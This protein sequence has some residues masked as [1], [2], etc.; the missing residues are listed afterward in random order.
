MASAFK[1]DK[2]VNDPAAPSSLP[3]PPLLSSHP[4]SSPP[5]SLTFFGGAG[6]IGGNKILL[7]TPRSKIYLDFGQSFDFGEDYFYEWLEPRAANGLECY[8]EFGI[9]PKIPKLYSRAQLQF[10]D[11]AYER[12]DIDG[13]FLS[14]HHSDHVG[15]LSFLDEE[16]PLYM[17]HGTK[18]IL[19]A[20]S[21]LFPSLVDIGEHTAIHL[22][23]SGDIIRLKDLVV[24]PIHVEHSTPGAYGYIIDTPAGTIAY[25]GDFRR[26][27]PRKYMTDEFIS[28]AARSKP[29]VLLCE[30]TRMT[31][32]PEK[33]YSEEEVYENVYGIIKR[34]KGLVLSEFSMCNIDRF[35]SIFKAAQDAGRT[36]V[37]DTKYA[38][39]L[40][41]FKE[42][43]ELPDPRTDKSLKVYYKLSKNREF[44]PKDYRPYEQEYMGNMITFREIRANQRQYVM[45]TGFNKLMELIYIR[46]ENA[47]YVYSS[48]ESFLE[49]EENKEQ[50]RVL[51][52]WLKHFGITLHKA[53]CSGHAGKSDLKYAVRK[54]NPEIL[55][56]I[57]TQNPEEFRKIHDQV[58]IPKRGETIDL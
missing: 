2:I 20:Y 23:K 44:S 46:P 53:H 28:E 37:V 27:G 41:R 22:F 15:H 32:D 30:G 17:G 38:F 29:R 18:G 26:H 51:D 50:R 36:F 1:M 57:H 14:H 39:L 45:F 25:T 13:V 52:N 24:R 48:S 9:V 54:I 34:S 12:S 42:I 33:H 31:P 56:P 55:I 10:T 19:D 40:D 3:S 8:F 43:M 6:E 58:I 49:G 4:S 11:L 35:H 47:D 5:L 7:Q 16:I 21:S